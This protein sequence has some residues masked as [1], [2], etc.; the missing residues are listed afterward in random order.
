MS[1]V[2]ASYEVLVGVKGAACLPSTVLVE[3]VRAVV[4]TA[5]HGRTSFLTS[6]APAI[7]GNSSGGDAVLLKVA[8]PGCTQSF[9][10][11]VATMLPNRL[12]PENY[13]Q[14]QISA[15]SFG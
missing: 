1:V 7:A 12:Q 9:A 13:S 11:V 10:R 14:T 15:I 5:A 6:C 2:L 3:G 4:Q 8:G